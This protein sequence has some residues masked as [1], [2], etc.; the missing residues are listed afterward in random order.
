MNH[1]RWLWT[2]LALT[3]AGC[4]QSDETLIVGGSPGDDLAELG[5]AI[6]RGELEDGKNQVMAL[7]VSRDDGGQALCSGTLFA[8]R[9]ILTA[10]HCLDHAAAVLAYFG[11]DFDADFPQLFDPTVPPENWRFGVEW[12]QHPRFDLAT[13]DSDVAVVHV[14]R[15]LPFQPLPLSFQHVS[16][17]RRGERVAIVGYGA[18]ESDETNAGG[19]GAF[20]KRSGETVF[21]GTP[22]R[23]PLPPNPHP[24]L[25]NQRI[26]H[27]LMQLDGSAPHS[28]ACFGDSGGPAL[29]RAQG[30]K[31]G[32]K[33][34]V[35]VFSWTGDFCEDFS[36][37]VRLDQVAPFVLK[38]ARFARHR[39]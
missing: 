11:N 35:G 16:D 24:G 33:E 3:S 15:D 18:E 37:Y 4:A 5:Q 30:R 2:A 22:P 34:V 36:Y 10:G 26:R 27:Q 8:P 25:T 1:G 7:L 23:R 21:Q 9:A 14:D 38:E 12:R 13:L 39:E 28:N 31:H 6:V 19:P 17:Q 29:M 20:I 32:P